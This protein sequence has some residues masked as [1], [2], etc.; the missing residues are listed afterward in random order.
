MLQLQVE[1]N[2]DKEFNEQLI[3]AMPKQVPVEIKV[4]ESGLVKEVKVVRDSQDDLIQRNIIRQMNALNNSVVEDVKVQETEEDI[5]IG[6]VIYYTKQKIWLLKQKEKQRFPFPF[7]PEEVYYITP[8]EFARLWNGHELV[9]FVGDPGKIAGRPW[10]RGDNHTSLFFLFSGEHSVILQRQAGV[11]NKPV[12]GGAM[13][14]EIRKGTK[15]IKKGT[16][17]IQGKTWTIGQGRL[18]KP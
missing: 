4:G 12:C 17:E 8:E 1:R 16:W 2:D 15:E 10:L 7:E 18:R 13:R 3:H 14:E 6:G 9:I 5:Y 11:I